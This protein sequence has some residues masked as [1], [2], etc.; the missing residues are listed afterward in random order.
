MSAKRAQPRPEC[1]AIANAIWTRTTTTPA[2]IKVARVAVATFSR[3]P[4]VSR[5]NCCS[6]IDKMAACS[7]PK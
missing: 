6:T 7:S 1:I 3:V 2:P 5:G 4:G